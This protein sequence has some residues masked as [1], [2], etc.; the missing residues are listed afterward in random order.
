VISQW[1]VNKK[2]ANLNTISSSVLLCFWKLWNKMCFQGEFWTTGRG[3]EFTA[4]DSQDARK[5]DANVNSS[6][7]WEIGW[8]HLCN[9]RI[10]T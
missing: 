4:M 8:N 10:S 3:E 9:I 1:T 5:I 7:C 2:L 6:W